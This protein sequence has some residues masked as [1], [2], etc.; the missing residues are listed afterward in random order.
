MSSRRISFVLAG[1]AVAAM[2]PGPFVSQAAPLVVQAAPLAAAAHGRAPLAVYS[3]VAP[4]DVS[5]S[6]LIARVVLPAGVG[7]PS[8]DVTLPAKKGTKK[9]AKEMQERKAG[10]TT[11]NAFGTLLVC[12]ARMPS[13][14]VTASIAGRTI[15]AAMPR[16][17]DSVAI[18]GDSGCRLKG[19]TVQACN[20]SKAWPL[21]QISRSIVRDRPDVTVFLGDFFYREQACPTSDST[22]CGGSPAPLAGVPFTDSAWGWVADV[23]TPMAPLLP[24][25][26]LVV[27]RGNHELCSRGGNGFFLLFDPAFGTSARCAPTSAGEAPVVYSPTWAVDLAVKGGRTLRLVSVDS[28]NGNDTVIDDTIAASQRPLFMRA[29]SLASKADEAWL[30]THRP[31]MSVVS[32]ELL[33]VPP[34]EATTWS[35]VTQAYSSYGLLDPFSLALSSHVHLVQ[36]AQIPGQPGQLVLGNGG[37]MLDPATGYA[38]PEYGPLSDA[39]GEPLAPQTGT[40]P[41]ASSLQTWVRFGY[42]VATPAASGWKLALKGTQGQAFATCRSRGAQLSCG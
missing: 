7:C 22:L 5:P 8:L 12:E 18:L 1:V 16:E 9:V 20:D 13:G 24:A 41:T 30:L 37:T 2:L 32:T 25:T 26:P 10:A 38:I 11:L 15:P 29:R 19:S 35:S 4:T 27:T 23:L 42:A 31:L 40:L 21:A 14:A 28:A 6:G 36:A 39:S 34:G 17:I 3:L 33:P